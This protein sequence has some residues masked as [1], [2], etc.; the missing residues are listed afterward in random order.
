MDTENILAKSIFYNDGCTSERID[1]HLLLPRLALQLTCLVGPANMN[2]G[3]QR[4]FSQ[5]Y[6]VFPF[7][8]LFKVILPRLHYF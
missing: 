3:T 5:S 6:V 8:F 2:L 4:Y 1:R 7:C